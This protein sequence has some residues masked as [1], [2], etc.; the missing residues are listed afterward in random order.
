VAHVLF[1]DIVGYT[2]QSLDRQAQMLG[3]LQELLRSSSEFRQAEASGELFRQPSGDGMALIFLRRPV[4]P[5][6]CAMELARALRR[7]PDLQVRMG[8]HS[9]PV[10]GLQ[11]IN[12]RASFAGSGI[13]LAQRVMD[14]GD[15]AHILLSNST[16]EL[17]QQLGDWDNY[18]HD[19]GIVGVKHG[20]KLHIYN[21]FSDEIGNH[22][23]P[24]KLQREADPAR[25]PTTDPARPGVATRVVLLYKRGAQPDQQLLQFL[26]AELLG[27]GFQVFIDRHLSI[28]VEW[29]KEIE[30]QVRSADVV[31]PLLSAG[32]I[33]SEMLAYEVELAHEAAQ[34]RG[35]PRLL[36]VRIN[37]TGPLPEPLARV[38]DPLQYFLWTG[39]QD[40]RRLAKEVMEAIPHLPAPQNVA[41]GLESVGGAVSLDSKYYVVRLIDEEFQAAIARRDSIVLVKGA[42]QMGKTS[43]LARGLQRAREAGATIIRTDFQKL[44]LAHLASVEKLYLVLVESLARQLGLDALTPNAWNPRSDPTLNFESYLAHEVLGKIPTHVVWGLDEVDR[45]FTCAFGSEVFGLFRSWHNDRALDPSGPWARLTLAIAYATEAHLFIS[46]LNQ[47]P[48]NVGT[49]LVLEDFNLNHVADLNSRYGSP[50]R[51]ADELRRYY[52][53]VGGHPYLVR[54]G[55]HEMVSHGLDIAAFEA[56]ADHDE[57]IFGDHLRRIVVLLARDNELTKVVQGV[58]RGQPCPN[59]ETFYRLRSAGL[60]TGDSPRDVRLRCQLY[61]SYLTKHLL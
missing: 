57:G 32:A 50:L 38:L 37:D 7:Q 10:R 45:L 27:Q 61:A 22:E 20:L 24:E 43:L 14:C 47:S 8:I 52:Q 13:N 39:P 12:N 9:G 1:L 26:E 17:L 51:N 25:I 53:R 42:R 4:A 40:N 46:D 31:V 56:Q 35:K 59:S 3:C 18:L 44:S 60:M 58:L 15:A 36:P 19:L 28:G 6:L 16:A 30:H 21:F 33:Q 41:A 29:A 11:D 2:R 48:F 5:V 49:R 55:L 34:T 23:L 54:R